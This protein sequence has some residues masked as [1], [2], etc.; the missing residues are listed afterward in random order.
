MGKNM[1]DPLLK[2]VTMAVIERYVLRSTGT[3]AGK[4]G[5]GTVAVDDKIEFRKI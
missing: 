1:A 2:L 4:N 3:A 5:P